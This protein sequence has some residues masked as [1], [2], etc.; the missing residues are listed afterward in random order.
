MMMVVHC[1]QFQ[2]RTLNSFSEWCGLMGESY[3]RFFNSFYELFVIFSYWTT[4]Y[5]NLVYGLPSKHFSLIL[6]SFPMRSFSMIKIFLTVFFFTAYGFSRITSCY[7]DL[8]Y[9][10]YNTRFYCFIIFL[11]F[12]ENIYIFPLKSMIQVCNLNQ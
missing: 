6:C 12:V 5:M 1:F 2:N 7:I 11:L 4:F 10:L 3:Q 9:C 8:W